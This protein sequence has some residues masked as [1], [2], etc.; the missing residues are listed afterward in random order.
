MNQKIWLVTVFVL[1]FAI[2][3][4]ACQTA[5]APTQEPVA[6]NA[7]PVAPTSEPK[8]TAPSAPQATQPPAT[9]GVTGSNPYPGPTVEIVQYNPY[10]APVQGEEIAWSQVQALIESGEIAEVFQAYSL[11]ITFT[12]KDGKLYFTVA[13]A[14]DEIFKL[15]DQCGEKCYEIR[16][17]SE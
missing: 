7:G 16:R 15:L 17:K 9:P 5:P 13:P 6:T 14:K 4:S 1:L 10:P 3:L 11:Q 12:A 8:P 2:A